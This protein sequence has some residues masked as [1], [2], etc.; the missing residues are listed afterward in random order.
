METD[1]SSTKPDC[2]IF[3]SATITML[4]GR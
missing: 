3:D 4:E 2:S 1:T